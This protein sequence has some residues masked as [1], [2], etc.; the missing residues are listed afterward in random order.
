[1]REE[2]GERLGG[3]VIFGGALDILET[4]IWY[5]DGESARRTL[6]YVD[7]VCLGRISRPS[8]V[9]CGLKAEGSILEVAVRSTPHRRGRCWEPNRRCWCG[10]GIRRL[11]K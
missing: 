2:G 10:R 5:R 9:I 1:M 11:G 3:G 6:A 4:R 7:C 8:L